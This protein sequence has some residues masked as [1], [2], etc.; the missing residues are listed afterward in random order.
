MKNKWNNPD[1]LEFKVDNISLLSKTR[2]KHVKE[3]HIKLDIE[4][5]NK[6]LIDELNK[7]FDS[8]KGGNCHLK[9]TVLSRNNGKNISV[10]MISRDIK[11]HLNDDI[12]KTLNSRSELGFLINK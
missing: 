12:I 8:A 9:V 3:L 10:D 6:N 7:N 2:E 1:E 5:I 4:N 11:F